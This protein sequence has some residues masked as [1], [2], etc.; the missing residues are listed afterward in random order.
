MCNPVAAVAAVAVVQGVSQ[1]VAANKAAKASASAARRNAEVAERAAEVALQKG[2][3]DAATVTMQGEALEGQQRAGYAASGVVVDQGSA[4]RTVESTETVTAL[5]VEKIR[6][7]AQREAWGLRRGAENMRRDAAAMRSA[8][9]NALIGGII[10]GTASAAS[11]YI[12][13]RTP[14]AK[15]PGAPVSAPA[16]QTGGWRT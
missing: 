10:S 5:D 14:A 6:R 3:E 1:G 2:E 11:A 15:P 8:G 9:R 12:G 7:D 13:S 4:E 16:S